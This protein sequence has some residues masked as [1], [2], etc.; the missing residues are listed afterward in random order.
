MKAQHKK[1][2]GSQ[3]LVPVIALSYLAIFLVLMTVPAHFANANIIIKSNNVDASETLPGNLVAVGRG[4]LTWLGFSIYQASLWTTTGQYQTIEKSSPIALTIHYEKNI[5]SEALSERTIEE[6][7]GLGIFDKQ[8]RKYWGQQLKD[9]W[10]DVKPGDQITT[11][12]TR[13]KKT[14][15]Y[16]NN[17]LI[18]QVDDPQ[19]GNA[20][21]SIW[22]HPDTSE[23]ELRAK[24]IGKKEA[25][26]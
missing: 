15:F 10:P 21:L 18:S 19:L 12:V 14:S 13:N 8:T 26:Q 6:W 1:Q 20:L 9:I 23:P 22:L 25:N 24:L 17:K 11:L 2:Q 4:E 16:Y 7:E 5:S 3:S